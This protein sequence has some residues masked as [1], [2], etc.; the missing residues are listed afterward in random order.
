MNII[1]NNK[2]VSF[3]FIYWIGL[4]ACLIYLFLGHVLCVDDIYYHFFADGRITMA[5]EYYYGSWVMPVQNFFM[6]YLPYKLGV[7]IQDWA[8]YFGALFEAGVVFIFIKYFSKFFEFARISKKLNLLLTTI[9]FMG[10]FFLLNLLKFKDILI[11]S[12]F[13]RFVLPSCLLV[14]WCYY[15]YKIFKSKLNGSILLFYA[16]SVLTA[17]S[18]E[19]IGVMC[20]IILLT[21]LI[22]SFVNKLECRKNFIIIFILLFLGLSLLLV[23]KGFQEHFVDK[24]QNRM[25]SFDVLFS[26]IIPFL[27]ACIKQL[28]SVN[29][30]LLISFFVWMY[31]NKKESTAKDE[32]IFALSLAFAVIL[33]SLSLVFLGKTHYSGGYW[34]IHDDIY[35]V[36]YS[37]YVVIMAVLSI[38]ILKD[39]SIKFMNILF[40]IL[41]PLF[42][43][44]VIHL[45]VAIWNIKDISY[46]RD[47]MMLHYMA[48]NEKVVLPHALFANSFYTLISHVY[49]NLDA[50]LHFYL[51]DFSPSDIK[52][53]DDYSEAMYINYY[54][55]VYKYKYMGRKMPIEFV[56]GPEAM[57]Y[58]AEQGGSWS[59]IKKHNYLFS[60]LEIK[61]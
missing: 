29:G 1:K 53:L 32:M 14:V 3:V 23:T 26:N 60:D 49:V 37:L 8:Q 51:R 40:V 43:I 9:S 11:Y 2:L 21:L 10:F 57:E 13:F 31:L 24:L 42:L 36:F 30:L 54:P 44:S 59:E 5:R 39:S 4:F 20:V 35:T 41:I 47:K 17:S 52:F 27:K 6:Y 15:L 56:E 50:F 25:F 19:M 33:F 18:S 46:L 12:G 55:F 22:Y 28:F 61:P 34:I 7:N 38:N 48:K 16:F 58:F 45:K